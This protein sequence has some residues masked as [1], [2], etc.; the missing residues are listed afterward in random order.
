[1]Y[2][3]MIEPVSIHSRK[4]KYVMAETNKMAIST[5]IGISI[6]LNEYGNIYFCCH[7]NAQSMHNIHICV[8]NNQGDWRGHKSPFYLYL[9]MFYASL[10][11]NGIWSW[12]LSSSVWKNKKYYYTQY[13]VIHYTT[14]T[15][16]KRVRILNCSHYTSYQKTL[17]AVSCITLSWLLL[18]FYSTF[19]IY[20]FLVNVCMWIGMTESECVCMLNEWYLSHSHSISII[21]TRTIFT[22]QFL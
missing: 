21:I 17:Y 20:I 5:H 18:D 22:F 8:S 12:I 11:E 10:F 3:K 4:E 2:I 6:E 19:F 14:H 16:Q 7:F 9:S 15:W 13:T 1:M